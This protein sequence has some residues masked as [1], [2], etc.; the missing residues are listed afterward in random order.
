MCSVELN[1]SASRHQEQNHSTSLCRLN[2][3]LKTSPE[4]KDYRRCMHHTMPFDTS[5]LSPHHIHSHCAFKAFKA[6]T[7]CS[8]PFCP[9]TQATCIR[10]C[11]ITRGFT[12]LSILQPI[13][14]FTPTLGGLFTCPSCYGMHV[15]CIRLHSKTSYMMCSTWHPHHHPT[16]AASS[17][18]QHS[19]HSS[20][21]YLIP[22]RSHLD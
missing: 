1:Q 5:P 17:V 18:R 2:R 9:R 19:R 8:D 22:H 6:F 11:T 16:M 7:G 10:A 4:T 21:I 13:T 20:C 15:D 12:H 14:P 3:H